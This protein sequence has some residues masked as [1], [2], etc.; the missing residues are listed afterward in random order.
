MVSEPLSRFISVSACIVAA[1]AWILSEVGCNGCE[2]SSIVSSMEG[3]SCEGSGSGSGAGA[4]EFSAG[5]IDVFSSA[6]RSGGRSAMFD[7]TRR[8][9][10]QVELYAEEAGAREGIVVTLTLDNGSDELKL[11]C[12]SE[13]F[14]PNF[15]Y[16]ELPDT[17][18]RQHISPCCN[19]LRIPA[20]P[21][22]TFSTR[23][24]AN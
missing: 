17:P 7:W 16:Q 10:D 3:V 8:I 24:P 9:E 2:G 22:Y 4:V 21:P 1:T 20:S 13:Y 19:S 18:V 23:P 14:T 15:R 11:R 6:G 5:G 12:P